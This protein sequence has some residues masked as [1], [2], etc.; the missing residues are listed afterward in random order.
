[1]LKYIVLYPGVNPPTGSKINLLKNV[2]TL[3]ERFLPDIF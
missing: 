1:M 3:V 2:L